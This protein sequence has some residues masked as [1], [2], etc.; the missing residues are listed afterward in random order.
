M[1][2]ADQVFPYLNTG[3]RLHLFKNAFQEITVTLTAKA[4]AAAHLSAVQ[5]MLAKKAAWGRDN[6]VSLR[7]SV[8][9]PSIAQEVTF[10]KDASPFSDFG[11]NHKAWG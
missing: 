2:P 10:A 8:G 9:T 5:D 1:R 3:G 4:K 6:S 11:A 7:L